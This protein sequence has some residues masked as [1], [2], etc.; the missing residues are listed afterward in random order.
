MYLAMWR[1]ATRIDGRNS[2]LAR[3]F[4]RLANQVKLE[5]QTCHSAAA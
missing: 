4:R 1:D 3:F 2:R 5:L